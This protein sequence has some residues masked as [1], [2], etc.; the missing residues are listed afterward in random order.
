M[1]STPRRTQLGTRLGDV[2]H[3]QVQAPDTAGF[4]RVHIEPCPKTDRTTRALWCQLDAS[5]LP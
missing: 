1:I 5:S 4:S 3:S 2:F